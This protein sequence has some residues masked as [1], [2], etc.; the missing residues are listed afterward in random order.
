M[1]LKT[2]G[3]V[4]IFLMVLV[5]AVFGTMKYQE[6][7]GGAKSGPGSNTAGFG[8]VKVD[9]EQGILNR[10]LRVGVVT[11]PGYMG[12]VTANNGFAPNKD[13]IYWRNHKLLVEF[14]LMEDVD[15]R[16]KAFANGDVD[17]VWS[18]VDFL[19]NEGPGFRKGGTPA[20]AVMQVDWSRGG[21]AIVVDGSINRIEDLRGKKISL[22]LFTPSHWLLVSMLR[23]SSLED[24]EQTKI[25]KNLVG[26]N[27][28]PD[29][30]ADF[31]AGKVDAAVVWEPD[32]AEALAKRPGSKILVS[33]KTAANLI[34][35]LMIA[36]Q[37][38]IDKHPDVIRAFIQGWMEGTEDANRNLDKVV[39]LM[40]D[41]MP[42]Y[43]DLGPETSRDNVTTV[44]WADLADNA[45]MFGLDGSEPLFDRIFKDASDAW[46]KFGYIGQRM[47]PADA[48]SDQMLRQ[49]FASIPSAER[50]VTP[51]EEFPVSKP[52]TTTDHK[53]L[54]TKPIALYF[55]TGSSQL[56]DNAKQ[57][58]DS[59]ATTAHEF[60]NAYIG[61]EG[62]TDNVGNAGQNVALSE[63]R[64][65]SVVRYLVGKYGFDR[66]RFIPK[67]NGPYKPVADNGS[68][69]GRAR[70][71][72]TDVVLIKR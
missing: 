6:T 59:V 50:S 37:E 43:K 23:N 63:K 1:K 18:T 35:D 60:S 58:L 52:P 64:A 42:L 41:N 26:K 66:N 22:A 14:K 53:P 54:S 40:M 49:I 44:K 4:L 10:P 57:L 65:A 12:G 15:V 20:K 21:D 30:R 3:K 48:K 38:F 68:S 11:W 51:K 47:S 7:Q 8:T 33:S 46:V 34:A 61:V 19:A 70:N 67:G 9:G 24:A 31:V 36:R 29:A 45:K 13:C 28:S 62:N 32:V 5:A 16:A 71:R 17:V 55:Q 69:E 2:P 56:D 25:I 27:A 39:Q 72:R